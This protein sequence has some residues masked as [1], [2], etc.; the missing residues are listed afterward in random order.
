[1]DLQRYA[2]TACDNLGGGFEAVGRAIRSELAMLLHDIPSLTDMTLMDDNPTANAETRQWLRDQ[3]LVRSPEEAAEA[4]ADGSSPPRP[5]MQNNRAQ[6]DAVYERAKEA[7]QGGDVKRALGILTAEVSK[8]RSPRARFMRQVQIAAVMVEGGH[9]ALAK[10]I[11]DE[12]LNLVDTHQLENWEPGELIAQPLVLMH[13]CLTKL[14][15]DSSR[16]EDIYLRI[17]RLDPMQALS[18][19]S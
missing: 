18:L 6:Y 5:I 19:Q 9:D 10:P 1:L 7:I 12:L 11:L 16:R 2:V 14:D 17:A 4:S 15:I 3:G 8:E 13:R